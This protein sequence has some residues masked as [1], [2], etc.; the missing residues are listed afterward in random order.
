MMKYKCPV[1]GKEIKSNYPRQFRTNARTHLLTHMSLDDD[2]FRDEIEKV[3]E[4]A[5][6]SEKATE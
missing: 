1:C 4:I 5:E 6:T 3:K 2:R